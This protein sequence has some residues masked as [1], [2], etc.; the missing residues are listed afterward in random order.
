MG[1][2][3][4]HAGESIALVNLS[5]GEVVSDD[6]SI[7]GRKGPRYTFPGGFA[8]VGLVYISKLSDLELPADG[9]RLALKIMASANF[10]GLCN[11]SNDA[12]AKEIGISKHRIS[13]LIHKL[14]DAGVIH[15][16]G[17]RT[18]VC[19]PVFLWQGSA[20]DQQKAISAWSE[21]RRPTLV[22][23]LEHKTA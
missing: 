13:T 21:L 1:E 3:Q 16:L 11:K 2:S 9:F 22:S 8:F 6:I 4:F 15:R 14:H 10:G 12:F 20:K 17:P 7:K 19:N 23:N 18:V 5:T